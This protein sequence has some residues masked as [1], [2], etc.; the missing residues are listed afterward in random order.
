MS[1]SEAT[2]LGRRVVAHLSGAKDASKR[3][4]QGPKEHHI[5]QIETELAALKSTA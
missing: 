5:V 4:A 2:N 3:L 1:T